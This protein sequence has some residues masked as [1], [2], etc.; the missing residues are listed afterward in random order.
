MRALTAGRSRW[1][2]ILYFLTGFTGL[3]AEQSFERYISLLVGA[4]VSASAVVLFAYFLGFALGGAAAA[5][6]IRRG[7]IA[8]PWRAYGVIELIIGLACIGI[9]YWFHPLSALLAPLQAGL[10]SRTGLLA[11]RF[12]IGSLYLLPAAILMGA[13]FP[14]LAHVVDR[15]GESG[16]RRWTR[17]YGMN[18]AGAVA[19]TALAPYVLLPNLGV[20]G[21]L[22]L[23]FAICLFVFLVTRRSAVDFTTSPVSAPAEATSSAWDRDAWLLLA[24]AFASGAVFFALEVLWTHLIGVAIGASVYAFSSML[25]MVLVGLYLAARRVEK[26][27]ANAS[28]SVYSKLFFAASLALMVQFRS[29]DYVQGIFYWTPPAFLSSMPAEGFVF[30]QGVKLLITAFLIVPS[31]VLIGSIYPSLLASPVLKSPGR[32]F[33]VGHL[34]AWNAAGCLAGALFALF[35]LIPGLGSEIALKSLVVMLLLLGVLFVIREKQ[36]RKERRQ[37]VGFAAIMCVYLAWWSW[38]PQLLTSGSNVYFGRQEAVVAQPPSAE[39]AV[40]ASSPETQKQPEREILYFHEDAQGGIT[41]VVRESRPTPDGGWRT[42]R[43]LFT[44]GK[45]QGDDDPEGE[46]V[47]QYGFSILP[48]LF[49]DRR[50]TAMLIGLGTGNS[51]AA[52]LYPGYRTV[53][54]AEIAAGIAGAAATVFNDLN[55]DV[56]RNPAVKLHLEDGRNVLLLHTGAPFDLI[57]IELNSIWFAGSTNLYSR[58]FYELARRNLREDGV[59][60]Q[61]VQL[62]HIGMPELACALATARAVFP[63]VSFWNVGGQ[64]MIIATNHEQVIAPGR[65]EDLARRLAAA[66]QRLPM[67]PSRFVETIAASQIASASDVDQLILEMNPVINTDHNRWIEY[68]TPLY[69]ASNIDWSRKNLEAFAALR[70]R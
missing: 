60:Q 13:S 23:C 30:A 27:I 68:A 37:A 57:T 24:A 35:V 11:V 46:I 14:L 61:W 40:A 34:N 7:K 67:E 19:A 45:F 6:L 49:T 70:A 32:T 26:G 25:L 64:G 36:P 41:T 43:T 62:H 42:L 47:A 54:A 31:A 65:K 33:L 48:S 17:L 56:L 63:Y 5:E 16:G 4:T 53:H 22:W 28:L 9:T 10:E 51:A 15:S 1:P 21:T 39:P 52:L 29:W 12:L 66:G 50:D 18:L 58:E 69:N 44:N 3:L 8:N 20:R 55:H 59:M 2:L 38:D